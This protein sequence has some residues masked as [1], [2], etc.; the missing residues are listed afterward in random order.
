MSH[1]TARKGA[2][3]GGLSFSIL[4]LIMTCGL[5][6]NIQNANSVDIPTLLL[7]NDIHPYIGVFMSAVMIGVI[8]N[9]CIGMLYPFFK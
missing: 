7:A 2:F 4:L 5:M 1:K 9:S 3:Y 6:A 8:F